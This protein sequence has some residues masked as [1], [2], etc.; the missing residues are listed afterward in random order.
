MK[1]E[2]ITIK[3]ELIDVSDE[4]KTMRFAVRDQIKAILEEGDQLPKD[5][6]FR[7]EVFEV[8]RVF[9]PVIGLKNFL[10]KV[11]HREL[12]EGLVSITDDQIQKIVEHR[13][14]LFELD[15]IPHIEYKERR[16]IKG[17]PLWRRI[18]NRF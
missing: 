12:F 11:D 6:S 7:D 8:R 13:I 1:V 18:F 2:K 15:E 16:R 14:S 5:A 3:K 17:L 10:V 4:T 9:I